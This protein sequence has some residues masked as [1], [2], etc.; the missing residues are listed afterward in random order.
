MDLEKDQNSQSLSEKPESKLKKYWQNNKPTT[1]ASW[2]G[3][4]I[5][6]VLILLMIPV[7]IVNFTIIIKGLANPDEAP[8]VFGITPRM[9]DS[10]SMEPEIMV[11]DLVFSKN[12]TD[13]DIEALKNG[14]YNGKNVYITYKEYKQN[15]KDFYL[16]THIL[17]K[18]Y[19][20]ENGEWVIDTKGLKNYNPNKP[21]PVLTYDLDDVV[22]FYSGRIPKL[23]SFAKFVSK[24]LGTILCII[25]PLSL[26][27][28][29]L[30]LSL[31][32]DNKGEQD[33]TKELEAEIAR[34]KA[35]AEQ[36][37][38]TSMSDS[39]EEVEESQKGK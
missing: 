21:A 13:E 32:G 38:N 23:G 15:S 30:L 28:I 27:V 33:K 19:Q 7:L 25:L 18:V 2:A 1:K 37:S 24:P 9:V 6:S 17:Q 20:N 26:F 4:I 29:V 22:G 14:D 16:V 5:G 8:S 3:F 34:L 39:T 11:G 12:I 31:K 10:D 35:L 36:Q